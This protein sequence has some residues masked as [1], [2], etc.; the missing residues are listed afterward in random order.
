MLIANAAHFGLTIDLGETPPE[1]GLMAD[2]FDAWTAWCAISGQWKT[3]ALSGNWGAKIIWLGI[4]Y[5]AAKAAL[6]LAAI[7]VTPDVWNDVRTIEEG[8]IEELNRRG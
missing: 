4:D 7:T 1:T 6:D 3:V 2:H 5:A 8:A